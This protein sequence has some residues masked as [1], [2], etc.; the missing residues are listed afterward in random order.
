MYSQ[1][2]KILNPPGVFITNITVHIIFSIFQISFHN[3]LMSTVILLLLSIDVL[4]SFSN[5]V[6]M[7]ILS[8]IIIIQLFKLIYYAPL[9]LPA[10]VLLT[11]TFNYDMFSYLTVLLLS[12]F[13]H[14]QCVCVCVCVHTYIHNT[15][16]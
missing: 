5:A 7:Y 15:C 13:F 4:C 14:T 1:N 9:E 6:Y 3:V 16:T 8:I 10:C 2:H 12:G 11:L